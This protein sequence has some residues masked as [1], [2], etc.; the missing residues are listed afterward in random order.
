MKPDTVPLDSR[1]F[2]T[3]AGTIAGVIVI[4]C[5]AA[6]AIAPDATTA[7]AGYVVHL[8]LSG[9]TRTLDWGSFFSGLVFWAFGTGLVFATA[10]TL[11]NRFSGHVPA[12]RRAD[13]AVDG[14]R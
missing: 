2:G 6:V 4:V 14:P 8:D 1:A 10:G 9:F 7:F 3:A 13:V 12:S 11:Y 5:S